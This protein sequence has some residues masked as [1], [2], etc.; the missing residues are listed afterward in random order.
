MQSLKALVQRSGEEEGGKR[1]AVSD[2]NLSRGR[3]FAGVPPWEGGL[4]GLRGGGPGGLGGRRPAAC[5]ASPCGHDP[6]AHDVRV[7]LRCRV[8]RLLSTEGVPQWNVWVRLSDFKRGKG[9]EV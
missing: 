8:T 3:R 9:S 6:Q 7:R 4:G 2:V 1:I 5:T